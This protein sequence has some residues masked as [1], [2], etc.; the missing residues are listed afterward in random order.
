MMDKVHKAI[1][2]QT[3]VF[4]AYQCSLTEAFKEWYQ[5]FQSACQYLQWL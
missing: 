1:T 4:T 5:T 3:N 2:T